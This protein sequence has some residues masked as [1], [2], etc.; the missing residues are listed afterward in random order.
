MRCYVQFTNN[1]N[2][3]LLYALCVV[4]NNNIM[5]RNNVLRN[6]RGRL[7]RRF[8]AAV[9]TVRAYIMTFYRR[10]K[11]LKRRLLHCSTRHNSIIIIF[12]IIIN[13]HYSPATGDGQPWFL[14]AINTYVRAHTRK[15]T[16]VGIV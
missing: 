14:V 6:T 5:Y 8:A 1:R 15:H 10:R 2:Y 4:Y 13:F 16:R 3:Y 9:C 12:N 7:Y 11:T